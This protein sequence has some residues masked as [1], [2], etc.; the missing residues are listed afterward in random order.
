[1]YTN[2][3]WNLFAPLSFFQLSEGSDANI[4]ALSAAI[5]ALSSAWRGAQDLFVQMWHWGLQ[6]EAWPQSKVGNGFDFK[7]K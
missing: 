7:V 2:W 5:S 4:V 6:P 3:L 1:M